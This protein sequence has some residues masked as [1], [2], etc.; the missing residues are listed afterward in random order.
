[1]VGSSDFC[2]SHGCI[3]ALLTQI[4][5]DNVPLKCWVLARQVGIRVDRAPAQLLILHF[6]AAAVLVYSGALVLEL[7]VA[8][9][10]H[11]AVLG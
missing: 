9:D 2:H 5:Y 6:S 3:R 10:R 8:T 7:G 11:V 4:V 1:M